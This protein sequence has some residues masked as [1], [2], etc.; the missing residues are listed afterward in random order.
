VD[1]PP[2]KHARM[3]ASSLAG[4]PAQP[5]PASSATP[6]PA[7]APAPASVATAVPA[8]ASSVRQIVAAVP[9]HPA[10]DRSIQPNLFPTRP[11]AHMAV[12]S[13]LFPNERLPPQAQKR[14]LALLAPP[15]ALQAAARI[16]CAG[17]HFIDRAVGVFRSD[18]DK[19]HSILTPP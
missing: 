14:P 18:F 17:I 10:H 12:A 9:M 2:A 8:A 7:P 3:S 4:P 6:A 15:P 19:L 16:S 13:A 11:Q 5:H 1:E